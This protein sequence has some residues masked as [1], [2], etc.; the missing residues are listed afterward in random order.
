MVVLPS[1]TTPA[2]ALRRSSS[3]SSLLPLFSG[4]GEVDEQERFDDDNDNNSKQEDTSTTESVTNKNVIQVSSCIELPFSAETAFD[5][6][7]N[8][9][10]QASWSPWLKSVTYINEEQQDGGL[11]KESKWTMRSLLGVSYSWNAISTK[12]ERPHIIEWESCRGLKNWGRVQFTP[13]ES[14]GTTSTCT[15]QLTLTFVAPR[16]L[17]RL[18]RNRDGGL[19]KMVQKR[20]IGRTLVRFRQVVQAEDVQATVA[21]EN[22][23]EL[24]LV[25]VGTTTTTTSH[26]E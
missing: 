23:K 9:P 16:V 6:F 13:H 17:A 12:L 2:L 10:R 8:L 7:S 20:I 1:P 15:M 11:R 4:G 21:K 24:E 22:A 3:S 26:S 14:N 19:S 5:A 18:F 25:S